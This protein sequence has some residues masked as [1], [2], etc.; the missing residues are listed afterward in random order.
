VEYHNRTLTEYRMQ[1]IKRY[2][3]QSPL[4]TSDAALVVD[5]YWNDGTCCTTKVLLQKSL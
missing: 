3:F 2:H 1:S 5:K 4:D